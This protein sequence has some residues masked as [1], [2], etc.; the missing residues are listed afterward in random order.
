ME[1]D[2]KLL[3]MLL[4]KVSYGITCIM[5]LAILYACGSDEAEPA[6]TTFIDALAGVEISLQFTTANTGSPYQLNDVVKFS[7]SNTGALSIDKNPSAN[8]GNE[9]TIQNFAQ[10]GSEYQWVESGTGHT[11][12]LSLKSDNSINE[13]NLNGSDGA[14]LGQFTPVEEGNST[15]GLIKALAGTYQVANVVSG[16][17]DRMNVVIDADGNIDFDTNV[18]LTT[19]TY[20]LVTDRIDVLNSI[21]IDMTPYPTEPY[22]RAEL[23]LNTD[24]TLAQI[25]YLP[26]YPNVS[27]RVVIDL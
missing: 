14:F 12:N 18:Q 25:S 8:D 22:A 1:R 26:E 21:F 16:T 19:D 15:L 6:G 20:Q 7:F 17:H 10:V 4:R 3:K 5:S 13:M 27:G 9:I 11:Y 2:P 23:V 24:G